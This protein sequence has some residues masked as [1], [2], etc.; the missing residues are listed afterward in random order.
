M[1][2]ERLA[3][4]VK[5]KGLKQKEF[6]EIMGISANMSSRYLS[7]SADISGEFIVKLSK[8]FPE[9]DLNN[10]FASESESG[11]MVQEPTES[12]NYNV[13]KEIEEIEKRLSKVK[14]E[15]NKVKVQKL[16]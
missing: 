11:T 15:L 7:G 14:A 13:I 9:M 1:Y 8:A 16:S 2:Y 10:I 5:S 12:Y 3:R 6:A 4:F